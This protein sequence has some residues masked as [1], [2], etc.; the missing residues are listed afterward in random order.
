MLKEKLGK[1][2]NVEKSQGDYINQIKNIEL[3]LSQ[4]GSKLMV[5]LRIQTSHLSSLNIQDLADMH[6]Q[7]NSPVISSFCFLQKKCSPLW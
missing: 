7:L 6:K 4:I 2:R 5:N 3:K 1:S